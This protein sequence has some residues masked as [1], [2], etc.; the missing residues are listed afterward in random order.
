[1]AEIGCDTWGVDD[2]VESQFGNKRRGLEEEGQWLLRTLSANIL[3]ERGI[4]AKLTCPIPPE[5]PA[6]TLNCQ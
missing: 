2:I 4:D 1:V 5:A 3:N 6:T